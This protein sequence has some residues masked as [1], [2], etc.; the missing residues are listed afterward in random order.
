MRIIPL[1]LMLMHLPADSRRLAFRQ[2]GMRRTTAGFCHAL[3]ARVE[4]RRALGSRRVILQRASHARP[5][6]CLDAV[7]TRAH[8]LTNVTRPDEVAISFCLSSSAFDRR[9]LVVRFVAP[10][11]QARLA[12]K[13]FIT[14]KTREVPT[15][16]ISPAA[17]PG[18]LLQNK[19]LIVHFCL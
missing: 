6:I 7:N 11:K 12:E 10:K 8:K 1:N 18:D 9:R 2:V 4:T 5:G 16:V 15:Q 17:R 3:R 13:A 14:Y 19:A